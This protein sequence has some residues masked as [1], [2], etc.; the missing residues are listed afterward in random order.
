M[1][2]TDDIFPDY[3]ELHF[4][5]TEYPA[6][7]D[8]HHDLVEFW[9]SRVDAEAPLPVE[10]LRDRHG[11]FG[12]GVP[13][14]HDIESLALACGVERITYHHHTPLPLIFRPDRLVYQPG[15][16]VLQRIPGG[17]GPFRHCREEA[18]RSHIHHQALRRAGLSW[19]PP[20]SRDL[21]WWSRDHKQRHRNRQIYHGLR[22][23]SLSIINRMIGEVIEA[24]ADLDAIKTARQFPFRYRSAL[25]RAGAQSKRARQLA[26]VFP[27]AAICV[28]TDFHWTDCPH[29]AVYRSSNQEAEKAARSAA[30][31]LIERGARLRDVAAALNI[32]IAFRRVK[33]LAAHS[34]TPWLVQH[35]ELLQWLPETA[36]AQRI[37]LTLTDY[38]HRRDPEFA[39]WVAR[40]LGEIPGRTLNERGNQIADLIDWIHACRGNQELV[41]RPFV[42]S[43]SLRTAKEL[44]GQWHEAVARNQDA[45]HGPLPEPWLPAAT[46][47]PFEIVP[48]TSAI[49]LHHEGVAM[50]NCVGSYAP[51]IRAGKVFVYSVRREGNRQ[52]TVSLLRH[53]GQFYPD[54][55]RGPCN[56]SPPKPIVKAVTSWLREQNP[57]QNKAPPDVSGDVWGLP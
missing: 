56:A 53:R 26:N 16:A 38:A 6:P 24:A 52:A 7:C 35:P 10:I 40:H 37:W 21:R 31:P 41:T 55:I 47:G 11:V 42:P 32:P 44:S 30:P 36:P 17:R 9:S 13:A 22:R 48:I 20:E 2:D 18:L 39:G 34:V 25:Y 28:Y 4:D 5:P 50:R 46:Q 14:Q 8:D 12:V 43:M 19:P 15:Y 57:R 49:D 29:A 23:F 45:D 1:T 3:S 33:P 51:R 54:Q 27:L